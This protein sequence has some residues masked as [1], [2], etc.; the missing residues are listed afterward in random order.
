MI[1]TEN[2]HYCDFCGKSQHEV[3]IIVA[4]PKVDI[5]GDCTMLAFEIVNEDRRKKAMGQS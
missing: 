4:G 5:C 1:K 3:D 2:T